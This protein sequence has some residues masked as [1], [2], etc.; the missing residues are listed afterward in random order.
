MVTESRPVRVNVA[1]F[2]SARE[3]AGTA[4]EQLELPAATSLQQL[5]STIIANHPKLGEIKHTLRPLLN[6][7]SA[8]DETE[9]KDRDRIAIIPPVGGGASGSDCHGDVVS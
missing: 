8:P 5:L 2:A 3:C 4:E 7:K 9:L 1:Y 6:G